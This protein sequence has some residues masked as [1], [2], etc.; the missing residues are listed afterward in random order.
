MEILPRRNQKCRSNGTAAILE[1]SNDLLSG[2]VE[3]KTLY[4]VLLTEPIDPIGVK[5]LKEHFTVDLAPDPKEETIV[6][7]IGDYD[8]LVIRA[9]KL[10]ENILDA[11]KKLKIPPTHLTN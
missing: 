7:L 6:S 5:L 2:R 10:T 3:V 11:G 1:K 8:A 4:K 9:T